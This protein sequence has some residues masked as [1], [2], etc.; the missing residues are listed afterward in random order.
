MI[1]LDTVASAGS[2]EAALHAAGGAAQPSSA[3]SATAPA[4]PSAA[5]ARPATTP[6]PRPAMGFCLFNNVAVAARHALAEH[7]A[8]RVLIL[9][10][11]VHHGNGTAGDLLRLARGPL[12]EHPPEPALSRAPERRRRPGRGEG[13][14]YTVNLPVPPGVG[15][16]ASSSPWSSTSSCRSRAS[17]EPGLIVVSAGYDA[18]GADPLAQCTLDE[19]DYGEMAAAMR[20]LGRRARGRRS[21]SASRAATTSTRSRR[22]WSRRLRRSEA[23]GPA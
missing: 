2:Y 21:S 16:R 5:C 23:R 7:G 9:D 8:E 15:R 20:D 10:W 18:H 19:R 12:R 4:S 17:Y 3:C 1:D 22:R 6:R 14:G 13:E 11:D